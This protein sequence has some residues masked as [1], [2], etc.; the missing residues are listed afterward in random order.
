M[1]LKP[2]LVKREFILEETSKHKYN[3]V[4][5]PLHFDK[6]LYGFATFQEF[7]KNKTRQIKKND[8]LTY[9]N[10]FRSAANLDFP[11]RSFKIN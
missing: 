6:E 10:P 11:T 1:H 8:K 9:S 5:R 2:Y 7:H 3:T 4:N